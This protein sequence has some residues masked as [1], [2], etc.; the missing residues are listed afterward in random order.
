MA[1]EPDRIILA[2]AAC[3]AIAEEYREKA[4]LWRLRGQADEALEYEH[5]AD[6]A[7]RCAGE[8]ERQL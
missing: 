8:V 5:Y 3:R 2:A 4:A 6:V 7:E 1:D